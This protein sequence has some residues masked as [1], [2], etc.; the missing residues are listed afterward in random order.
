MGH[1]LSPVTENAGGRA[2]LGDSLSY[3]LAGFLY[4]PSSCEAS[5]G[6]SSPVTCYLSPIEG[7]T[8]CSLTSTTWEVCIQDQ[9]QPRRFCRDNADSLFSHGPGAELLSHSQSELKQM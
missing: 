3:W 7:S 4:V 2:F 5:R 9:E 6:R 1:Q 8:L